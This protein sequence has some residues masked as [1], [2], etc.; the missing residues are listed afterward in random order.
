M[1]L[2]TELVFYVLERISVD[3]QGVYTLNLFH[4]QILFMLCP[5]YR[6]YFCLR[7]KPVNLKNHKR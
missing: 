5:L 6:A 4:T 7:V 2:K 3:L 1:S